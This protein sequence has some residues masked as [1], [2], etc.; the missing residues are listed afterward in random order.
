MIKNAHTGSFRDDIVLFIYLFKMHL[1]ESIT[2]VPS[3]L[4]YTP[5]APPFATL[6]SVSRGR[7]Y[8]QRSPA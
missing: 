7:A 5:P 8:V 6:L 3:F 1:V 4:H 2:D